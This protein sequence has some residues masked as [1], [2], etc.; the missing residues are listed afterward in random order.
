MSKFNYRIV[1]FSEI[2]TEA[3]NMYTAIHGIPKDLNLG[4]VEKIP[5]SKIPEHNML[6]WGFPCTQISTAGKQTGFYTEDGEKTSSGLFE[7]GLRILKEKQPEFSI[8]ENV[9]NLLSH[10]FKD[11]YLYIMQSLD[12]A[13]YYSHAEILNAR[14]Y[15]IPQNRNRLFIVSIRK[16]IYRSFSFTVSTLNKASNLKEYLVDDTLDNYLESQPLSDFFEKV[17]WGVQLNEQAVN[18]YELPEDALKYERYVIKAFKRS[19]V[20]YSDYVDIFNY[21]LLNGKYA[22]TLT[23]LVGSLSSKGSMAILKRV[24]EDH[25]VYIRTLTAREA[26]LLMGFTEEDYNLMSSISQRVA[27]CHAL[28]NSIVV[29]VF[30]GILLD[31]FDEYSDYFKDLKVLTLFSGLGSP[32]R[33][34]KLLYSKLE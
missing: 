31:L 27:L 20:N 32:E 29:N 33:A 30:E 3:I 9:P 28:G 12:E 14:D 23:T 22:L 19:K 5:I 25:K 24:P 11:L 26:T 7:D 15:G 4:D 18:A 6:I 2:D 17:G 21:R 34:L 13:G 8:I 16:D 10:A 1:G